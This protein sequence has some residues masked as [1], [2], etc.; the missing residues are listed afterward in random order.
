M[1]SPN[2][3]A[4]D[5]SLQD[6]LVVPLEIM[7]DYRYDHDGFSRLLSQSNG[8][9]QYD[10]FNRLRVQNGAMSHL[11]NTNDVS[12]HIRNHTVRARSLLS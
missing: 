5:T 11:I 2:H 10:K 7:V 4:P 8:T 12:E 6:P 3:Q 1:F 9:L